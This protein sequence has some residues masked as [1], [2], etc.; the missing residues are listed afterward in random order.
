MVH[1]PPR[2]LSALGIHPLQGEQGAEREQQGAARAARC[3]EVGWE[4]TA[5]EAV[6]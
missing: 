1:Q 5:S 3:E 6:G 2:R 4:S